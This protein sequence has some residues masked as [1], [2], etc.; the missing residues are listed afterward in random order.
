MINPVSGWF[1]DQ[2]PRESRSC[3]RRRGRNRLNLEVL[4]GRVVLSTYTVNSLLDANPPAGV[5]TLR[6]AIIAANN[7]HSTNPQNPDIIYFAVDGTIALESALPALTGSVEIE[8]PGATGLTIEGDGL[9]DSILSIASG[10]SASVS[11]LTLDGNKFQNSAITVA[12]NASLRV[13]SDVVQNCENSTSGGGILINGG[14]VTVIQSSFV[15]NLAG[16][17]SSQ[18]GGAIA[19]LGGDLTI[20]QSSFSDDFANFFGGAVFDA[21]GANGTGGELTVLASTF[22]NNISERGGAIELGPGADATVVDSTFTANTAELLGGA[23]ALYN[24]VTF[25]PQI[26]LRLSGSTLTGNVDEGIYVQ[27]ASFTQP[28]LLYDSIIA[29]N[30]AASG[31]GGGPDVTGAVDPRSSFNLIGDGTGLTGLTTSDNGNMIGSDAEPI[32]AELGPLQNNGG[33]TL[34][35]APLPGSPA[36]DHCGPDPVGDYYTS[37]DQ[38]GNPRIVVQPDSVLPVGGDGRDIG[39]IE[40]AMQT[41]TIL[42]VNS[43]GD[44]DPPAGVLTLRQAIEAAN[45]SLSFS[46]LPASQVQIGSPYIVQIDFSVTGTI[47]LSSALPVI[48]AAAEVA[49]HGPGASNLTI[50]GDG[51]GD[52]MFTVALAASF[53]LESL[54]LTEPPPQPEKSMENSGITVGANAVFGIQDAVI[55]NVVADDRG[56]AIFNQ[57]GFVTLNASEVQNAFAVNYGA[58]IATLGGSIGVSQCLFTD[59]LTLGGGGAIDVEGE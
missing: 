59:N 12:E 7:D 18:D 24:S 1:A 25:G 34:T 53:T 8:G 3:F 21:A 28:V 54:T 17:I 43:T 38:A 19:N 2:P 15:D 47:A 51:L 11:G 35:M 56:G 23:I 13:Q 42:T 29:G 30:T 31:F 58:D 20:S 39:A 41:P 14:T 26:S 46:S 33:P 57:A 9:D 48:N 32:N 22:F 45:G 6:E 55:E 10:A 50:Q 37:T 40:L 52:A 4:E 49:L 36:I 27:P 16:S 5:T 44:A